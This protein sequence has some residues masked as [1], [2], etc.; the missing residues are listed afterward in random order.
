M[1]G[2]GMK[3]VSFLIVFHSVAFF[4][5]EADLIQHQSGETNQH[6]AFVD[7][8][9]NNATETIQTGD[10]DASIFD[11]VRITAQALPFIGFVAEVYTA[12]FILIDNTGLPDLFVLIMKSLLGF[13]QAASIASFIRGYDF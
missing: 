9:E 6:K 2:I 7:K 8:F 1:A 4:A 12:P 11:Q 5:G 10:Q 3:L 13:F